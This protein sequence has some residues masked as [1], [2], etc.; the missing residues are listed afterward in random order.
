M[1]A[2]VVNPTAMQVAFNP[3]ADGSFRI[4]V[5]CPSW[6]GNGD[7]LSTVTSLV[8]GDVTASTA[9]LQSTHL[10][11]WHDFWARTGL[12][13]I[14]SPEGAYV[15]SLRDIDLF[16]TAAS[17]GDAVPGHHNGAAD[18]FKWNQDA[19]HA[20]WPVYEFWHWNLRDMRVAANMAAGH[21]ELNAPYFTAAGNLDRLKT[22]TQQSFSGDGA[23]ICVP[24]IMRFNGNGAGG[25]GNQAC[26]QSTTTWNGKTLSTGA[27]VSLWIWAHYSYTGDGAYADLNSSIHGGI[28]PLPA[29]ARCGRRRWQ[30]AHE[31]IERP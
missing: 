22:W 23:N 4:V 20:G 30:T 18:L 3:N 11:F 24:E 25:G 14:S 16:V 6:N 12:L 26:D 17:S 1:V 9:S 27:E 8:G 10:A 29:R 13:E 2:S 19:W 21:P 15:Q 7:A 5:A 31:P 28:S